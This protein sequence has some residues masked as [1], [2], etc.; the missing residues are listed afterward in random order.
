MQLSVYVQATLH[1]SEYIFGAPSQRDDSQ[2]ALKFASVRLSVRPFV[3]MF[4]V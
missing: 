4:D 2:V 1:T 3:I